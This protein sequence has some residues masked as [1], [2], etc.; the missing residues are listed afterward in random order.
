[1]FQTIE[2][3]MT[4]AE[5][6][7]LLDCLS[8]TPSSLRTRQF[9]L[10][11]VAELIAMVL[12]AVYAIRFKHIPAAFAIP[13]IFVIFV[14][15]SFVQKRNRL[16]ASLREWRAAN[17]RARAF[18]RAINEA[19]TVKVRGVE[20]DKVVQVDYNEGSIYLFSVGPGQTYW[21]DPTCMV[22]GRPPQS[23]PN[24][25]FEIVEVPG[26]EEEIGPFCTGKKLRPS[27][28]YEFCDLLEDYDLEQLP[29]N[30]LIQKPLDAF[31]KESAARIR[32]GEEAAAPL[33]P[34]P[35]PRS[36]D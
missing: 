22:P 35:K 11:L 19:R 27:N 8:V 12:A 29:P 24:R 5:R 23:W 15:L 21:V 33:E 18:H 1:M 34:P 28:V 3:P 31:L 7:R 25:K 6:K 10:E 14:I 2:R 20:S 36:E 9:K 30:G 17:E 32:S 16:G 26:W 4:E 13:V